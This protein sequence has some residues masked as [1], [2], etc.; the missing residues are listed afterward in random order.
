MHLKWHQKKVADPHCSYIAL[1]GYVKLKGF[2]LFPRFV[3]SARQIESQLKRTTTVVGYTF[4]TELL[5]LEFW[6]LSAWESRAAIHA[7]VHEQPH[8]RIMESLTGRLGKTD[9]RY[10]TVQG[11]ELPLNFQN[12]LC[13]LTQR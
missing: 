13:R 7:F 10:W 9:F 1:L 3:W 6:H 8:L 4:K 2:R 5:N 12:E 11:S